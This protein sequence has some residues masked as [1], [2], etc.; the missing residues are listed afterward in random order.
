MPNEPRNK[1]FRVL[2]MDDDMFEPNEVLAVR[3]T[4]ADVPPDQPS[5]VITITIINDDIRK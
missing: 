3:L 4:S 2:I 5:I 1:S